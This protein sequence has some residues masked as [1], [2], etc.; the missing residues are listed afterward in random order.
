MQ[1]K[2]CSSTS[3]NCNLNNTNPKNKD[4]MDI[5]NQKTLVNHVRTVTLM[6]ME[7]KETFKSMKNIK[8]NPK[9]KEPLVNTKEEKQILEKTNPNSELILTSEVYEKQKSKLPDKNNKILTP[10]TRKR[11]DNVNNTSVFPVK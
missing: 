7:S 1:K 4:L 10:K 11:T 6:P 3:I 2:G 9:I 8:D 5:T